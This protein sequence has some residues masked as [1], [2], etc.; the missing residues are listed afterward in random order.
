MSRYVNK[1]IIV[2][3]SEYYEPLRKSRGL[4]HVRQYE[5]LM[6]KHPTLLDRIKLTTNTH[7][8]KYGDRFYKLSARY[9]NDP[10]LWWVIAW[11]NGKP[12]EADIKIGD[13]LEIPLN[14]ENIL[15]ALE[16]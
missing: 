16:I 11:Y 4:K 14:I 12:T 5:T 13:V 8:W 7:I 15:L 9:Y 2:N 3:S 10:R 6:L 1:R